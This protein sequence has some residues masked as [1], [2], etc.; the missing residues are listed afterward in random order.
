MLSLC[1]VCVNVATSQSKAISHSN[2]DTATL[3]PENYHF[4]TPYGQGKP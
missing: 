1:K 4:L 3:L 2:S